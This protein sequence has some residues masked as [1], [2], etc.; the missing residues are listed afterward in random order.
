[1][2]SKITTVVSTLSSGSVRTTSLFSNLKELASHLFASLP[3]F[4]E[5]TV[6]L[7]SLNCLRYIVWRLHEGKCLALLT[8]LGD[9]TM[10]ELF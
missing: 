2:I 9:Y 7:L 5:F 1:M 6:G 10:D 8:L 3:N 4:L